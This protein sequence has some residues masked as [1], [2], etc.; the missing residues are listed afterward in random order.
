MTA[1]CERLVFVMAAAL[2][3]CI[4]GVWGT[5]LSLGLLRMGQ[6][7]NRIRL[8][9]RMGPLLLPVPDALFYTRAPG[10]DNRMPVDVGELNY[11]VD[12]GNEGEL[13]F[14][15]T[16]LTEA[17]FTCASP[18]ASEVETSGL[19]LAGGKSSSNLSIFY[20][21][22]G[23][24]TPGLVAVSVATPFRLAVTKCNVQSIASN[25]NY[26]SAH[27]FASTVNFST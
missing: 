10:T 25:G 19:L 24:R 12:S 3:F 23:K 18:M 21:S 17:N 11:P 13:I 14:T 2:S 9:C 1:G 15:I 5:G 8:S 20:L 22:R 27:N 26:Y 6:D 16:P 4:L 7:Q